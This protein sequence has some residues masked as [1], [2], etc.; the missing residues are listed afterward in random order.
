MLGQKRSS[1]DGLFNV[2][3]L[4][5]VLD[6]LLEGFLQI[7]VVLSDANQRF[8]FLL[9]YLLQV[10]EVGVAVVATRNPNHRFD[11]VFESE[12]GG[13][14]VLSPRVVV[15]HHSIDGGDVVLAM[16]DGVEVAETLF[17]VLFSNLQDFGRYSCYHGVVYHMSHI[18]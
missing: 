11:D 1:V 10:L 2:S 18:G 7:G 5:D 6:V 17:D 12:P 16:L 4:I 3:D 15:V 13:I 9:G 14:H 8:D